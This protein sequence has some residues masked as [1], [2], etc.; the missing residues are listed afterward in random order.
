MN[1]YKHTMLPSPAVQN[2]L[3]SPAGIAFVAVLCGRFVLFK[4]SCL[5]AGGALN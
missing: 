4:L 1:K 2:V 5:R 3:K